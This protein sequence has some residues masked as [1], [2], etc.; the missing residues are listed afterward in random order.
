MIIMK[1]VAII[2]DESIQAENL[3]KGLSRV[4]AFSLFEFQSFSTK[5]DLL[6]IQSYGLYEFAVIDIRMDKYDFNGLDIATSLIRLN[7]NIKIIMISS[8]TKEYEDNKKFKDLLLLSSKNIVDILDKNVS[9]NI[10]L[11][12]V[13]SSIEKNFI[14]LLSENN[15]MNDLLFKNYQSVISNNKLSS[16]EKGDLFELFISSLFVQMG[17]S[18]IERRVIDIS[19]NEIDLILRN[20]IDNAFF[21]KFGSHIVIECKNYV[22]NIGKNEVIIFQSKLD[23]TKGQNNI[24]FFVTS[25]SF[26]SNFL[27]Q[28]SRQKDGKPIFLLDNKLILELIYS[29]NK[30]ETLMKI[31]DSQ[32]IHNN[33]NK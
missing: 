24:G 16:Y 11:E 25:S 30:L 28:L 29:D 15:G 31:M 33:I 5:E 22:D 13:K 2:D 20:D 23:M 12:L 32:I 26:N 9:F 10:W 1:T 3:V 19:K 4:D 27:S 18:H 17:F 14:P 7:P 21:N 8:F 6:N